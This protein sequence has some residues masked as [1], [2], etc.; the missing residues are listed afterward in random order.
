MRTA[1]RVGGAA[2][3]RM[4]IAPPRCSRAGWPAREQ[5]GIWLRLDGLKRRGG[6]TQVIQE[7]GL[8]DPTFEDRDAHLHALGDHFAAIQASLA[9][10]LRGRQVIRHRC[11]PPV[12]VTTLLVPLRTDG[13]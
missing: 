10:E 11:V 1:D 12:I 13:Y 9:R 4:T 8:V 3:R 2:R 6:G 7:Q 5:R